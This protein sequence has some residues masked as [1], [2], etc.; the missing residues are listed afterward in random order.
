MKKKNVLIPVLILLAVI[1]LYWFGVRPYNDKKECFVE[2]TKA[3]HNATQALNS[4][5]MGRLLGVELTDREIV[6]KFVYD[7]CLKERGY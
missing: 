4:T 5:A 6:F 2:A 3:S 7:N 1:S